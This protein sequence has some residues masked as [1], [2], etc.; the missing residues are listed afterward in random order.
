[1]SG[2]MHLNKDLKVENVSTE[3]VELAKHYLHVLGDLAPIVSS[4]PE[5]PSLYK[6]EKRVSSMSGQSQ[7]SSEV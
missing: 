6:R 2:S 7:E 4:W 1:M 5:R 3:L